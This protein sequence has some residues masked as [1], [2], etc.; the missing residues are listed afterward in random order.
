MA[1]RQGPSKAKA[2]Q[3]TRAQRQRQRCAAG[4]RGRRRSGR[5]SQARAREERR[6]A[7]HTLSF[8]VPPA[9]CGGC[10]LASLSQRGS[11]AALMLPLSGLQRRCAASSW[12]AQAQ[13]PAP[14]QPH[15]AA[16][17]LPRAAR[18]QRRPRVRAL[19]PPRWPFAVPSPCEQ[20]R[21][22]CRFR[23]WGPRSGGL[24]PGAQNI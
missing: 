18:V 4:A 22:I 20:M 16:R 19:A 17:S 3:R 13:R 1:A 24:S 8:R 2:G 6:A 10:A 14:G 5:S 9:S 23:M 15:C 12:A 11:A 7:A 21:A